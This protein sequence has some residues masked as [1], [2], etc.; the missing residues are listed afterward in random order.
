LNGYSLRDSVQVTN[1]GGS[2]VLPALIG[3][4]I[5]EFYCHDD[6]AGP[7]SKL[8]IVPAAD[9]KS[10]VKFTADNWNGELT[11]YAVVVPVHPKIRTGFRE[12][13]SN[14]I[15]RLSSLL[16]LVRDAAKFEWDIF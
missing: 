3:R 10:I 2:G 14:W 7:F 12:V 15:P 11:P 6:Q 16:S 5:D 8:K 13:I 9:N 1:E 4:R